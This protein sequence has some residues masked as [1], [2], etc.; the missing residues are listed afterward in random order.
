MCVQRTCAR[1]GGVEDFVEHAT[2]LPLL[3]D[4]GRAAKMLGVSKRTIS[5]LLRNKQLPR[6]KIGRR[7][8]IPY[9]ALLRFSRS[10]H[11]TK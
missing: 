4:Q 5:S 7:T 8:L 10:D 3:V 1:N 2:E 9:A 11:E 6:R